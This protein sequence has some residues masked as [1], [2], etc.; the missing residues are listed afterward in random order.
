MTAERTESEGRKVV[1]WSTGDAQTADHGGFVAYGDYLTLQRSYSAL[2]LE[3]DA[4]RVDAE[5]WRFARSHD[6]GFD[7]VWTEN[8]EIVHL[9]GNELDAAIDAAI[10][11][12][13]KL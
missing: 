11:A 10:L 3:R 6:W 9:T 4:L 7:V 2:Q 5:R 1:R 13:E 8:S 12:G